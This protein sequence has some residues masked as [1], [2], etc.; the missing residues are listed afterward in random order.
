MCD[1]AMLF[2]PFVTPSDFNTCKM[3]QV[4]PS[5]HAHTISINAFCKPISL[6]YIQPASLGRTVVCMSGCICFSSSAG[7][8]AC[9]HCEDTTR[10]M[11]HPE[12]VQQALSPCTTINVACSCAPHAK[13]LVARLFQLFPILVEAQGCNT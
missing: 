11:M 1:L 4:L 6:R 3:R 13:D 2:S 8:S 5:A 7:S 10:V 12:I 9:Q